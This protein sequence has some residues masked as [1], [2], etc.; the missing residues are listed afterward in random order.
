MKGRI[1]VLKKQIS[2]RE[3][4][5]RIQIFKKGTRMYTKTT[6]E[7]CIH[8]FHLKNNTYDLEVH[9]SILDTKTNR[10]EFYASINKTYYI[11]R[12]HEKAGYQSYRQ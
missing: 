12:M 10:L 7:F 11:D 9:Q 4:Q 5:N 6:Q 3:L 8:M 2:F 1:Q